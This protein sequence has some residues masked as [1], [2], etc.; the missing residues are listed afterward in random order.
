MILGISSRDFY[1]LID[2]KLYLALNFKNN[3][4]FTNADAST[5]V[6]KICHTAYLI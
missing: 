3:K 2:F 5:S 6:N 4:N 1:N